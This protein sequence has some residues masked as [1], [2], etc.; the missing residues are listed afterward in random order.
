MTHYVVTSQK[1]KKI[2]T[3]K[4][5]TEI[6]EFIKQNQ[7]ARIRTIDYTGKTKILNKKVFLQRY[8]QF[9]KDKI[10]FFA[11]TEIMIPL[12]KNYLYF[13]AILG[14]ADDFKDYKKNMQ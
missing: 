5:Y 9:T 11:L 4:S 6:A 3:S 7:D 8:L 13:I 2:L 12:A 14:L 10:T 1:S